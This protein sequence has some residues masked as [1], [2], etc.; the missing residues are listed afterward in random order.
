MQTLPRSK[1]WLSRRRLL[2]FLKLALVALLCVSCVPAL[3][4]IGVCAAGVG[5]YVVFD[6]RDTPDASADAGH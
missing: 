6:S 4:G 5:A 1:G 3:I 2:V